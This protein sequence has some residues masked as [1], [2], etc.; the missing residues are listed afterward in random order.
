MGGGPMTLDL[1]CGDDKRGD[2][3]VDHLPWP[4]VDHVVNLGF[5]PLPFPDNHFERVYAWDFMEHLPKGVYYP[6]HHSP[7]AR[8]LRVWHPHIMVFNEA[9]R[10]LKPD[11]IFDT[12][13]P[14]QEPAVNGRLFHFSTWNLNQFE[15]FTAKGTDFK[16]GH[17]KMNG[18]IGEFE[19]TESFEENLGIHVFLRA[20]K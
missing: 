17:M 20:I 2:I 6:A 13:T 14:I 4:G 18:F 3:G 15:Q 7:E 9:W 10:V 12:F 16:R 19:I 8:Y 11:G 5:E 1:G